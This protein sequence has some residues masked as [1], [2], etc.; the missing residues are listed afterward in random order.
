MFVYPRQTP[1]ET[2]HTPPDQFSFCGQYNEIGKGSFSFYFIHSCNY[3]LFLCMYTA[4]LDKY[5]YKHILSL[6]PTQKTLLEN[7]RGITV[8]LNQDDFC[9]PLP[10]A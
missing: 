2:H 3:L 6:S 4:L 10:R 9:H 1:A 5:V 7:R 8:L